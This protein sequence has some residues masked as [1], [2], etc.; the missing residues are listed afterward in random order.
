MY[1]LKDHR[2]FSIEYRDWSALLARGLPFHVSAEG[3]STRYFL[4]TLLCCSV[5]SISRGD[6][7]PDGV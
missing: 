6:R 5:R 4:P 1:L 3:P 2:A 7:I